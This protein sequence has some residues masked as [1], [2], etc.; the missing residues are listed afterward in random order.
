MINNVK[1]SLM[2]VVVFLFICTA[3]QPALGFQVFKEQQSLNGMR[4]DFFEEFPS[5]ENLSTASLIDFPSTIYMAA[6]SLEEFFEYR[7]MLLCINPDIEAAYWPILNQSYWISPYSYTCELE[8][9]INNLQKN[10][11]NEKLKVLLDLELQGKKFRRSRIWSH[12]FFKNRQLIT[13]L[14]LKANE[15]NIEIYTAEYCSKNFFCEMLWSFY[16]IK[17]PL[18]KFPHTKI[19]MFYST[20]LEND[21]DLK[22]SLARYLINQ[23]NRYGDSIQVGL[24][25]IDV[26]RSGKE[27]IIPPGLLDDDL[28]LMYENG[29]R[30]VSIFRLS[31]LNEDYLSVIRKYL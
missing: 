8:N 31:G 20:F 12:S 6:N 2:I 27:L 25:C 15:F 3:T 18:Y 11:Q 1:K 9:L 24:G 5:I 17:Y 29:I 13:Q 22:D 23:H 14:F 10:S 16:G 19:I 7:D 4:I 21:Y 28:K 26:G 30:T